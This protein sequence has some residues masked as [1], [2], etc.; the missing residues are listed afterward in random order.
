[1][2]KV[3]IDAGVC[4]FTTDVS[5]KFDAETGICDLKVDTKCPAFAKVAAKIHSVSPAEEACWGKSV[6]HNTMRENCSHTA[7]PV[8][9]GIVKAV[10]VACGM[11][12]PVNASITF[13][14]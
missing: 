3:I 7:C 5:A 2:T 8:P 10:Q 4:G 13:V 11:K 12:A 14:E 9:A 1:M 6:I